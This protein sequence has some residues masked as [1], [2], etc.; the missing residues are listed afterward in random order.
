MEDIDRFIHISSGCG[1]GYGDGS[2]SGDGIKSINSQIVHN[3]D[4]IRTIISSI[5][6]N[7]AKGY[8]LQSDLTLT[9]CYVVKE[10][11]KFAHGNTLHEAFSALQE[12]MYDDST[13][14]ER[15]NKFVENFPDYGKPYA[16][17]DLFVWHHILTGSCKAGRE[18]FCKDRGIDVENGKFT[19]AEFV[20]LTRDSY[21][22]DII[23]RLPDMYS[24]A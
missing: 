21:G 20:K 8:M 17:S 19:I 11:D 9:P 7:I 1:N 22:G 24:G 4:G 5:R 18:A 15:L 16:A 14:K 12:K 10:G 23:S 13:E 3:I 6:D 2:G